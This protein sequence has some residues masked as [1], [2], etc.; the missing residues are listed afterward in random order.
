MRQHAIDLLPHAVRA[1]GQAGVRMGRYI[2]FT[3]AAVVLVIL[4]LTHVS[5]GLKSAETEWTVAREKADNVISMEMNARDLSE[6]IAEVD[7]Y[8]ARYDRLAHPFDIT[9]LLATLIN[10]MPEGMTLEK[11]DLN[12]GV[13][14]VVRTPRSQG[15]RDQQAA[16]R[17]LT[18]EVTGF[19]PDDQTI[20]SFISTLR[21][22]PPLEEVGLDFSRTRSVRGCTA[23]EFRLSFRVNL[24][25]PFEVVVST[26]P[27]EYQQP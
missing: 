20:A 11:L 10:Q 15:N 27:S 21:S 13:R 19:A 23:R 22:H 14:R 2:G 25:L 6:A 26:A 17:E 9:H 4:A 5:V 3:S 16:P 18:A 24:D 8:I 1:R 7:A 12:A